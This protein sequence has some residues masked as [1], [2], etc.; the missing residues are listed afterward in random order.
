MRKL[1]PYLGL[2][3]V[4]LMS[5]CAIEEQ[6]T[7]TSDGTDLPYRKV[8]KQSDYKV[9]F[10]YAEKY[11]T[12]KEYYRAQ[13]LYELVIPEARTTD[14]G[15]TAYYKYADCYYQQADYYLAGYYFKQFF[16]NNGFDPRAEDALFKS[17]MCKVNLSPI[18]SLDQTET[19]EAI[20]NLQLFMDKYPETEYK[21]TCNAI[22][23]NLSLK[24]DKKKYEV[25]MLAY[26]T[27]NY[28]AAAVLFDVCLEEFPRSQYKESILFHKLKSQYLLADNSI[29]TKKVER[30]EDTIKSYH[31]FVSAFPESAFKKDA[32]NIKKNASK[33]LEAIKG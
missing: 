14:M 31:I 13:T 25:A 32:D 5:A 21:D 11:Y 9:I 23:D 29:P 30:F 7:V 33:F 16:K 18:Y 10:A 1:L 22:I 27:E 24:L 8:A 2:I 12:N 28:K 19:I 15:R 6:A 26:K 4:L 3:T 20:D 17:A